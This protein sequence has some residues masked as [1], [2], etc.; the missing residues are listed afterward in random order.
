MRDHLSYYLS[1]VRRVLNEIQY[2]PPEDGK[3]AFADLYALYHMWWLYGS[4]KESY[5]YTR[6]SN[7]PSRLENTIDDFFIHAVFHHGKV[8]TEALLAAIYDELE[9]MTDDYIIPDQQSVAQYADKHGIRLLTN[10]DGSLSLP[11]PRDFWSSVGLNGAYKLFAFPGWKNE[12]SDLYGGER[13][14][15]IVN[16]TRDLVAAWKKG[17]KGKDAVDLM[18]AIDKVYDL[19]HNTG[20]MGTKLGKLAVDKS[21]L[22]KRFQAKSLQDLVNIG[23]SPDVKNL[24]KSAS[25]FG[26]DEPITECVR[27]PSTWPDLIKGRYTL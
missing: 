9:N 24:A 27:E 14:M 26:K 6:T 12:K 13:W 3:T 21:I 16:A 7:L 10:A 5:G 22:D 1:Q 15:K 8:L 25:H 19:E 18:Y 2:H 11:Q 17:R 4:G 20:A 23:V